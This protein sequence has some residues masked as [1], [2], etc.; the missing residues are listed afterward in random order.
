VPVPYTDIGGGGSNPPHGE[1][2]F[3]RI[4]NVH[5]PKRQPVVPGGGVFIAADWQESNVYYLRTGVGTVE[6]LPAWQ[7]LGPLDFHQF[8]GD[9]TTGYVQG[10]AYGLVNGKEPVFVLVGG[11]GNTTAIGL[12]M[13]S[14]DGLNWSRVFTLEREQPDRNNGA[15]I[16]AVVWD[17]SAFWAGAHQSLNRVPG[18]D[19]RVLEYDIL[20]KSADGFSWSET[21]RHEIV[22]IDTGPSPPPPPIYTRGLLAPHCSNRVVDSYSN[23]LPDGFYGYN[24]DSMM[25]VPA[26]LPAIDY[27][28]GQVTTNSGGGVT[29]TEFGKFGLD[30]TVPSDPGIPVTCVATAN[31]I[32]VAAGGEYGSGDTAGFT[33]SSIFIPSKSGAAAWVNN[34]PGGT[35]AL[36]TICGGSALAPPA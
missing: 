19:D 36:I 17:G 12:I 34:S 4:V 18:G 23:G 25:V 3:N 10:S 13:A 6:S 9:S 5:W 15:N 22:F 33:A 7:N 30:T 11:G 14:Q 32:W 2:F 24:P 26:N 1:D 29:I 8:S 35:S 28:F 21:G 31:G 16:F 20:L 27:F